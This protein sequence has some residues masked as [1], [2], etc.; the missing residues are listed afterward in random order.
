MPSFPAPAA[1]D[2]GICPDRTR[3][4]AARETP[5][6]PKPVAAGGSCCHTGSLLEPFPGAPGGRIDVG[7]GR[8]DRSLLIG[9]GSFDGRDGI[10]T[11]LALGRILV[12]ESR[13]PTSRAT[14]MR[15]SPQESRPDN[16]G[17]SWFRTLCAVATQVNLR[18]PRG[19]PD[20]HQAKYAGRSSEEAMLSPSTRRTRLS[21]R[22]NV[23]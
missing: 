14:P 13:V 1:P 8:D 2:W 17:G 18:G 10:D 19:P 3:R 20:L 9:I 6:F 16:Q 15:P 21:P 4:T 23:C 22:S 7:I 5:S 12:V 11:V